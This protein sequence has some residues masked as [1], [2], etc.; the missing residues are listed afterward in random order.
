MRE[1]SNLESSLDRDLKF[2]STLKVQ[3][4][5]MTAAHENLTDSVSVRKE[6]SAAA[7]LPMVKDSTVAGAVPEHSKG[8]AREYTREFE[9]YNVRTM[10]PRRSI[11]ELEKVGS[12]ARTALE[13]YGSV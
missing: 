1:I 13:E 4:S 10:S 12:E 9:D 5:V 11:A 8:E 3:F 6:P 7:E 2:K